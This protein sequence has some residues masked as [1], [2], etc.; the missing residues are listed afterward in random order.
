MVNYIVALETWLKHVKK[1]ACKTWTRQMVSE[2]SL[3]WL[4]DNITLLQHPPPVRDLRFQQ[5]TLSSNPQLWEHEWHL[6]TLTYSRENWS[7]CNRKRPFQTLRLV[8]VYWWHGFMVWT[9]G[10]DNLQTFLHHLISTH[11]TIKFTYEY[12]NSSHQSLPFLDVHVHLNN[13]PIETD[14][15]TKPTDKHQYL[16]KPPAILPT[17]SAPSLSPSP[18]SPSHLLYWRFLQ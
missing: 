11:P 9:K 18:L 17:Q 15:H 13:S 16:L 4:T 1:L 3:K 5:P 2:Y 6:H 7:K 12:S 8:E 10:E 14:L